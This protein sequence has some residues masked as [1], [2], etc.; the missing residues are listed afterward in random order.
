VRIA[1]WAITASGDQLVRIWEAPEPC[2]A[3]CELSKQFRL[4]IPWRS[5]TDNE[6]PIAAALAPAALTPTLRS[7]AV[8]VVEVDATERI[9]AMCIYID[10]TRNYATHVPRTA[11]LPR[12]AVLLSI[13]I[14]VDNSGLVI[15]DTFAGCT[16]IT[17]MCLAE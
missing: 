4:S 17:A 9:S 11:T 2:I 5:S 12:G 1:S 3:R 6:D 10:G 7:L 13:L 16:N 8:F 14:L 15:V